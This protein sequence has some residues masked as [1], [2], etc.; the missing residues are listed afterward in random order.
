MKKT[1]LNIIDRGT[2]GTGW[3]A[4]DTPIGGDDLK[5]V[6]E[7]RTDNNS[8]LNSLP[9]PFARFFV[10]REAFRRC[11][12]EHVHPKHEAGMAYN[13]IVSDILDVYELLYNLTYHRNCWKKGQKV[14]LYEWNS[15]EELDKIRE[16]MPIL[17]NSVS[18]YYNNDIKEDKLYYVVYT[19]SGKEY[20]LGCSSPFTGF[21]TP[22]DMDRSL[23]VSS[24]VE[25]Y[26][27]VGV[28]YRNLHIR[29][30]DGGEYFH[31]I[32]SFEKRNADFKN[33]MYNQLFGSDSTDERYKEIRDFIRSYKDDKEIRN[34]IVAQLKNVL[35]DQNDPLIINGLSIM[36]S[37]EVDVNNFFTDSMLCV[38]YRIDRNKFQTVNYQ[39]DFDTRKFDYLMPLRPE[40]VSLFP[41]G[42]I[43][44]EVHINRQSVTVFLSYN[45]KTYE[46]E[47]AVEPFKPGQGRI[48]DLDKA[49]ISFNLGFFPNILSL[50]EKE[51]NY[52]K[53]MI[54]AADED[55]EAPNF[56]ID[57]IKLRFFTNDGKEIHEG[58]P[59]ELEY[60]ALKPYV[61]SQQSADNMESGTKFYELFNTAFDIIEVDVLGHKGLLL[62]QFESTNQTN[63][64]YTYAID[65]GTSNTFMSRCLNNDR[66]EPN[67]DR[68]PELFMMERAMVNYM[69]EPSDNKQYSLVRRI[70][71][72]VFEKAKKKVKTEFLPAIIDGKDYK[73]PI[74]TALCGI[75]MKKGK[76]RLFDNHNI[77]FFYER[78]MQADDQNVHT[79]IKWDKN[80]DMLRIFVRELL[81]IIKCDILQRGGDLS[82]T[83]IVWFSPLS[84]SGKEKAMYQ[85]IWSSEPKDILTINEQQVRQYS[86][87]E[88]PY[89]YYMKMAYIKDS[90]AVT[91]IDIGGGSTDFV[92]FKD[93]KPMEANSVHFGCDVL[94]GNGFKE[95]GNERENGIYKRY[96]GT[97]HFDSQELEDLN[98]CFKNVDT[99]S[100][101][102]IIN[103]WLS[104]AS[105]CDIM[106]NLR[107]DFMPIFVYHFTSILYYMA[108]MYRDHGLDA[109]RSVV[110]SGNGSKYIDG[111]IT[112]DRQVLR[113]IIN[114]V[115]KSV[116]G[117]ES[118][119]NISLPDERKES[120]CYG[121]LYRNP[122]AERV[123]E[124]TYQG[125][126]N[127]NV[128]TYGDI[129]RN[130][131]ALKGSLK[132][133]YIELASLYKSVLQLLK[134]NH[135]I[136]GNIDTSQYVNTA[137]EDMSVA[138][139]TQYQKKKD[140]NSEDA[141][142]TDSLFFLPVVGRVFE[143]T[144]L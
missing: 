15:K 14:E 7:Q 115:F 41:N 11:C 139:T 31:D 120:T 72:S 128:N 71:D 52:F 83:H 75:R 20:L 87:S 30:K 68:R 117:S 69:H 129:S 78:M 10:A 134:T 95:F 94:W 112:N 111:F 9:T 4:V 109:P 76:P 56:T 82:R 49:K 13:Q 17:Y 26:V 61:R 125:D 2:Q 70:E 90:D 118:G 54:V 141:I 142:Y 27:S 101:K 45:G 57:K 124:A 51:N 19:D 58:D 137:M 59:N 136:D 107:N 23:N 32:I 132:K 86:E 8:A 36:Q 62:P 105:Q 143:M 3:V 116:Y 50:K 40:V 135:I 1:D 133:K 92:Y 84:F 138:L 12:E 103:F 81:L 85:D 80:E 100:T 110:F 121:G 63:E 140:E 102:D 114:M 18:T 91:V 74:R 79:D 99:A 16:K 39:N 53:L 106:K 46:R 89:Y 93:N 131:D 47:Y 126:P 37:D 98:E 6:S 97:L 119:V 73:F 34:D 43:K 104:N 48:I 5:Y 35:T 42:K 67:L 38:P 65:L 96:S 25:E 108:S 113:E 127:I 22:P 77:A 24:G 21:V 33:Y 55:P 122:S 44:S 29:R 66:G 123:A 60:G 28:T 130:F 88:A 144:Q 64:S